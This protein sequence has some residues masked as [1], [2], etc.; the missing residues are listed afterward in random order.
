[1]SDT[2]FYSL[3]LK[4]NK[5]H[6]HVFEKIQ[7]KVN[8]KG[9][10]ANWTV[11]IN[12][13]SLAI[14][15]GDGASE[16]FCLTFD[17]KHADGFCKVAFPMDGE[18]FENQKKSEWK[19]FISILHSLKP[20]CSKI[21]VDDDYSIA[22]EYFKSLDYKFDMRELNKDEVSRL[23][24]LFERFT[25]YEKFLL[26]VFSEDTQRDYDIRIEEVIN[27][28]IKLRAP[29]PIISALWETYIYETSTLKKQCLREIYKDDVKSNCIS[30]DPPDEIYTFALGVGRLFSDYS[31]IDN[32]W[33]R[34]VDVTKYF[35]D[36]FMPVFSNADDYNKCKLAYQ[37]M[38]SVYDYCK[39]TFVGKNVINEMIAAYEKEHIN[40]NI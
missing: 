22:G 39:F 19:T 7:R 32:A 26:A 37:F 8:S 25:N 21:V 6:N 28:G 29:F 12:G 5:T 24:R 3:E 17:K 40:L 18:L 35:Y 1:M 33:G 30:G 13:Q 11:T 36:K 31:F 34:G 9:A 38:L 10:T 2:I 20:M 4:A 23:D 16:I 27:P 15:F 14:D